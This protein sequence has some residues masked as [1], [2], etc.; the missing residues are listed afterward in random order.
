MTQVLLAFDSGFPAGFRVS[1]T[2]QHRYFLAHRGR[3]SVNRDGV[4]LVA[5]AVVR[6]PE[7]PFL[8]AFPPV[9]VEF[10]SRLSMSISIGTAVTLTR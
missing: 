9:I 1:Y 10:F 3:N 7:F 2:D 4:A 5:E 6:P 8:K